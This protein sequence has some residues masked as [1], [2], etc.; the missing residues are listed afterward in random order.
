MKKETFA[1]LQEA[2]VC[3]KDFCNEDNAE[4]ILSIAQ[5][6][7][8]VFK[9]GNKVLICG[10][11]GSAADAMHFAEEFSGRFR[12]DRDPL[13]VI[14]FADPTHI[15]CVG[16]DFGFDYIFS[17][18]VKA[19]GKADDILIVISTS[20]NSQNVINALKA[21]QEMGLKTFGLIG[22]DGGQ[23][24]Y[25]ADDYIIAPGKNSD[26]IQE[27]HIMILHIIV[28]M[29]ERSLFPQNYLED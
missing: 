22:K 8:E 17:R 12:K 2:A 10:N 26:R 5:S 19:L 11:G 7:T 4:K 21:A 20:G 1:S 27:I 15:T 9:K 23:I 24:K 29:V 18:S 13:P 6:I 14:S 16:N 28:E 3:F 25:L